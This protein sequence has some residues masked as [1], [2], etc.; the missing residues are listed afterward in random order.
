MTLFATACIYTGGE[1]VYP[2]LFFTCIYTGEKVKEC[3]FVQC[4]LGTRCVTKSLG[5]QSGCLSS[6]PLEGNPQRVVR[7]TLRRCE[8]A[9][10][11]T[12]NGSGMETGNGKWKWK[13]ETEME[14]ANRWRAVLSMRKVG[15]AQD[16]A[17]WLEM[18]LCA[19]M[20]E[21]TESNPINLEDWRAIS[22][23]ALL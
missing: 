9:Y 11:K 10:G 22:H 17:Y 19:A 3:N 23:R 20:E 15:I 21:G 16:T 8:R 2:T 12:G 6:L 13:L 14:C 7:Y 5:V 1:R 18:V 4:R